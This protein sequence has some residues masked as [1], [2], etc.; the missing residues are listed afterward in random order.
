VVS[1]IKRQHMFAE[2]M[3]MHWSDMIRNKEFWR[4]TE[5]LSQSAEPDTAKKVDLAWAHYKKV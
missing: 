3:N 1:D 2:I 5:Q 4:K